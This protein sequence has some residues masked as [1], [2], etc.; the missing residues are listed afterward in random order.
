MW[1]DYLLEVVVIYVGLFIPFCKWA[2]EMAAQF[3]YRNWRL[4]V[5]DSPQA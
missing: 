2:E 5:D 1:D 3:P 4:K